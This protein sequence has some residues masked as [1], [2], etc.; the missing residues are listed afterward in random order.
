MARR[1]FETLSETRK[2]YGLTQ[3]EMARKIGCKQAMISKVE[4]SV[5]FPEGDLDRWIRNY[6]TGTKK[7]FRR[8]WQNSF[9]LPLWRFAEPVTPKVESVEGRIASIYPEAPVIGQ[10]EQERRSGQDRRRQA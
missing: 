4:N 10:R 7:E 2:A 1:K 5:R 3:P 9:D 8:R 6:K